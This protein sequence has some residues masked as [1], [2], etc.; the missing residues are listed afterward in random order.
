MVAFSPRPTTI[1][2]DCYGTLVDWDRGMLAVVT[3]ILAR[4]G[5]ADM[6]PEDFL[7]LYDLVE[8]RI[9]QEAPHRSF[10]AV[11]TL[12]LG[13]TLQTLRVPFAT[14]DAALLALT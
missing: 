7:S 1:T 8:H 4:H 3:Q 9:E 6:R 10:K 12:A 2:F 11:A 13:E 5:H 14:E